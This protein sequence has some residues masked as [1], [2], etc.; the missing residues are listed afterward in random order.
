MHTHI[1][2]HTS[3]NP[4]QKEVGPLYSI[5]FHIFLLAWR[6]KSFYR[7]CYKCSDLKLESIQYLNTNKLILP[8]VGRMM[9]E[10]GIIIKMHCVYLEFDIW[11]WF[12]GSDTLQILNGIILN[13]WVSEWET[14]PGTLSCLYLRSSLMFL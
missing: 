2:T 6:K 10:E 12:Q 13:Y 7:N 1:T 3:E 9:S 5:T 8:F 14:R 4:S 11:I